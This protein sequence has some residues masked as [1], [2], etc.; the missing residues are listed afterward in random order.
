MERS[1]NPD[2]FFPVGMEKRKKEFAGMGLLDLALKNMEDGAGP[3]AEWLS[4]CAP[5]WQPWVSLVWIVGTGL[6]S[7]MRPC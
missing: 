7:L 5:L 3:A 2:R 4:S 1:W 6:A